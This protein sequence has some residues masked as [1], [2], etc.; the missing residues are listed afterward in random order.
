MDRY[1]TSAKSKEDSQM[2]TSGSIPLEAV[3]PIDHLF[4]GKWYF[5]LM[6]LPPQHEAQTHAHKYDHFTFVLEGRGWFYS[7]AHREPYTAGSSLL[8]KAGVKHGFLAIDY[9]EVICAHENR[10]EIEDLNDVL[11]S[12]V[13]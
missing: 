8:V 11:V 10:E 3:D 12:L 2:E 5:R 9:T 1:S 6:R 13:K 7:G 4:A